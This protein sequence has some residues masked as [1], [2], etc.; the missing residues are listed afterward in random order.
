[1]EALGDEITPNQILDA[2]AKISAAYLANTKGYELAELQ[3]VSGA[4]RDGKLAENLR[5]QDRTLLSWAAESA[6]GASPPDEVTAAASTLGNLANVDGILLL[7]GWGETL[8]DEAYLAVLAT[9][10]LAWPLIFAETK[11]ELSA[12]L[13]EVSSGKIV[14]RSRATSTNQD[15]LHD[16]RYL[17]WNL[18]RPIEDALPGIFVAK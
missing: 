14:W 15:N 11:V 17:A 6:D 5:I 4:M 3:P 9:A 2:F 10:G 12:D 13:Y 8:S 18:L 1:M 16:I 7:Q